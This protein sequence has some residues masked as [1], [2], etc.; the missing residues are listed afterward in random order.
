M[1]PCCGGFSLEEERHCLALDKMP[2]SHLEGTGHPH[3]PLLRLWNNQPPVYL[4]RPSGAGQW[5]GTRV[6]WPSP[7]VATKARAC[8]SLLILQGSCWRRKAIGQQGWG[9]ASYRSFLCLGH[10]LVLP[11]S[12]PWMVFH[13]VALLSEPYYLPGPTS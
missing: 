1:Q 4:G 9:R 13:H 7:P 6:P 8:V 5:R 11:K 2:S 12:P 3:R 10:W